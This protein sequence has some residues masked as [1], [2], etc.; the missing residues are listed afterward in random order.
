MTTMA[1]SSN[2]TQKVTFLWQKLIWS[3]QPGALLSTVLF[4]E[5]SIAILF[6]MTLLKEEEKEEKYYYNNLLNGFLT[7]LLT[8]ISG[9][10]FGKGLEI[11]FRTLHI[12]SG[13]YGNVGFSLADIFMSL[14]FGCIFVISGYCL[15]FNKKLYKLLR[16]HPVD[17]DKEEKVSKEEIIA[18]NGPATE[19]ELKQIFAEQNVGH[20]A[21]ENVGLD[22]I[23]LELKSIVSRDEKKQ[24]NPKE[25]ATCLG[26]IM[27]GLDK[28]VN[29]NETSD[30]KTKRFVTYLEK[31]LPTLDNILSRYD[32]VNLT[33]INEIVLKLKAYKAEKMTKLEKKMDNLEKKMDNL[34]KKMTKLEKKMDNYEALIVD[35]LEA[36]RDYFKIIILDNPE[37]IV[38]EYHEIRVEIDEKLDSLKKIMAEKE[39]TE[40][41][42]KKKAESFG[43]LSRKVQ[44]LSLKVESLRCWEAGLDQNEAGFV[45]IVVGLDQIV[46]R[47]DYYKRQLLL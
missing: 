33:E 25:I 40:D 7:I 42:R 29:V 15:L 44:E 32:R 27:R 4:I 31:K 17:A 8:I 28:I 23:M 19:N 2:N 47:L 3:N 36:I 45:K 20:E 38:L 13:A 24:Q 39:E 5:I 6:I 12:C 30:L 9:F 34:E 37:V 22:E 14:S 41:E 11:F 46:N 35:K 26:E 10:I 16:L 43:T 21:L 1:S 18:D